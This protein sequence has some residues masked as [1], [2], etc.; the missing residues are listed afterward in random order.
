MGHSVDNIQKGYKNHT[1]ALAPLRELLRKE[2]MIA[3]HL[4]GDHG[5]NLFNSIVNMMSVR[6]KNF[7]GL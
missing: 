6:R 3:D 7:A 5:N 4:V 2:L 1:T